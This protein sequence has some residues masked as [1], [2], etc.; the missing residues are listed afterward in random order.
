[1]NE[2]KKIA[3]WCLCPPNS[4]NS[5]VQWSPNEVS[6]D[7][8]SCPLDPGHQRAG[9]RTSPL[10]VILNSNSNRHANILWTW[11]G[12]CLV[13][14]RVAELLRSKGLSGYALNPVKARYRDAQQI[15][16]ALNELVVKGWGGIAP[17]ES[18]IRQLKSCSACGLLEYSCFTDGDRLIPVNDWDGSD[19][20]MVW[21]LPRYIF[22]TDRVAEAIRER[23]FSDMRLQRPADLQCPANS[24]LSPGR[25]SYWMPKDDAARL[26]GDLDIA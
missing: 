20:F 13:T 19:F 5:L 17:M 16:P 12:E 25:L 2:S 22:V 24:T 9:K 6:L 14:N 21:P 18:G 11:Q 7:E 1:M 3:F 8:V 4:A 23:S 15:A 10:S 26:G